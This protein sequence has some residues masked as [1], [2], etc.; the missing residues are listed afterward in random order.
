M[1]KTD[2]IDVAKP[3]KKLPLVL[4]QRP[5]LESMESR[6][7]DAEKINYRMRITLTDG[8]QMTGQMLA[9]DK[10]RTLRKYYQIDAECLLSI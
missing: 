1:M 7:A 2:R 4:M 10:V 8:R 6:Q 9:F 3:G 5:R